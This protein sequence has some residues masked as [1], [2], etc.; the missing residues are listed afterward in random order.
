[1]KKLFGM[2]F[3]LL[4]A[5]ATTSAAPLSIE[6]VWRL[7]AFQ[8]PRLSP[9][10]RYF[11]VGVPIKERMNLAIVDLASRKATVLTNFDDYDV[12]FFDWVGNDRLVFSLGQFN[13]P[14]GD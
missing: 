12:S 3:A 14:D 10:G 2:L 13:T 4:T 9:N 7:P 1:M 8:N 5:C 6:D 11:A